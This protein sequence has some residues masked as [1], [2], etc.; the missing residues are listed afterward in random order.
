M[1]VINAQFFIKEDKREVF[2]ED[3]KAL[4]AETRKEEGCL[5]YHLYESLEE[6]NLFIMVEV[7][8]DDAAIEI[9]NQSPLLQKLF[10]NVA[11]FSAKAPVLRVSDLIENA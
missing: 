3:T 8:A 10:G 5:E 1:K 11:D 9:H 7:W 4:I 6:R 2:I